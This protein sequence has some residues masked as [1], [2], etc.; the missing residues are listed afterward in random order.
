[1]RYK[2]HTPA[3]SLLYKDSLYF[4]CLKGPQKKLK[5]GSTLFVIIPL[6]LALIYLQ[7][8]S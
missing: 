6:P 8:D 1:M 7:N 3:L 4:L 2:V 5:S